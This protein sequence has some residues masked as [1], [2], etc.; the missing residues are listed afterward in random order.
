MFT[1]WGCSKR[2]S[3]MVQNWRCGVQSKIFCG[4]GSFCKIENDFWIVIGG[5]PLNFPASKFQNVTKHKGEVPKMIWNL[6]PGYHR[7]RCYSARSTRGVRVPK[8]VPKEY[9][10][11]TVQVRFTTA[12]IMGFML[13]FYLWSY[14]WNHE[15]VFATHQGY[16]TQ[17]TPCFK[18]GANK[19][20]LC[21]VNHLFLCAIALI[22]HNTKTT[23]FD[24]HC[25]PF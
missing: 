23:H 13:M 24:S 20:G 1:R 6:W 9:H 25:C 2:G 5:I 10:W 7:P 14:L 19:G 3:K 22:D 16:C 4:V 21:V 17:E 11:C 8:G 18:I 15:I 12:V